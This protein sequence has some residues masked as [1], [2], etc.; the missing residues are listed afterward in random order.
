MLFELVRS[1]FYYN[2]KSIFFKEFVA[3]LTV[4]LVFAATAVPEYYLTIQRFNG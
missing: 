2:L 1:C 4:I 3:I